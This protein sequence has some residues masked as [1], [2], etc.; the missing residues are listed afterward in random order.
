MHITCV[1]LYTYMF[2]YEH[3]TLSIP[4][5]KKKE[6]S[7]PHQKDIRSAEKVKGKKTLANINTTSNTRTS[8][9]A[10]MAAT[11]R[12]RMLCMYR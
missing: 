11:A 10:H 3:Q 6:Y 9:Y 5:K 2:I 12:M 8:I 7:R 4:N 1:S